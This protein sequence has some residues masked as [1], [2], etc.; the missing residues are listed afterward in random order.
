MGRLAERLQ[1]GGLLARGKPG[2]SGG[3]DWSR[4]SAE[5][6]R[7]AALEDPIAGPKFGGFW[8][9]HRSLQNQPPR[10]TKKPATPKR[11]EQR[12]LLF[13]QAP[14]QPLGMEFVGKEV[15]VRQFR[16][17]GS[18]STLSGWFE[19]TADTRLARDTDPRGLPINLG[20]KA[21]GEID[22]DA[23]DLATRAARF[24]QVHELRNVFSGL[25]TMIELFSRDRLSAV[26]AGD[27]IIL[28]H[29]FSPPL[30]WLRGH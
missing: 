12:A 23:L 17:A 8:G 9:C 15:R 10:V 4:A 13:Q 1:R 7:S 29:K 30:G 18:I 3:V 22:V 14:Y 26:L 28:W 19:V 20:K 6:L 16:V 5:D 24:R 11:G 25:K 2:G 21:F 27:G